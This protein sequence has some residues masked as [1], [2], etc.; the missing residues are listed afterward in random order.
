M[1]INRPQDN[2]LVSE[3]LVHR[4]ITTIRVGIFLFLKAITHF[5]NLAGVFDRMAK[6]I[7]ETITYEEITFYMFAIKMVETIGRYLWQ[8]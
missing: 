3:Q 4:K 6:L 5:I 1:G 7:C 8:N 2:L